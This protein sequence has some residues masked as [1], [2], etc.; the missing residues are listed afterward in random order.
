MAN[1]SSQLKI[2]KS[3]LKTNIKKKKLVTDNLNSKKNLK[4]LVLKELKKGLKSESINEKEETVRPNYVSLTKF[5]CEEKQ[6]RHGVNTLFKLMKKIKSKPELFDEEQPIFLQVTC[7]KIPQSPI[8]LIR[9]NLNHSLLIDTS[10]ICLIVADKGKKKDHESTIEYYENILNKHGITNIKT[11]LPYNQFKAEYGTQ[12]ELK[13]KLLGLYDFFLVD[14]KVCGYV[15]HL[16]GSKFFESR[17]MPSIV[18]MNRPTLKEHFKNATKKTIL[19]M[20]S[21]GDSYNVQVGHTFM[22]EQHICE[23]IKGIIEDFHI[24]FPGGLENIRALGIKTAKSLTIPIYLTL[25]N[26]SEVDIP[27][28]E[29]PLP[30]KFKTVEGELS[31]Q[32]DAWVS[33]T[34]EGDVK[35]KNKKKKDPHLF[36]LEKELQNHDDMQAEILNEDS[37]EINV[38]KIKH[39]LSSDEENDDLAKAEEDYLTNYEFE[40]EEAETKKIKRKD[41][42]KGKKI[43]K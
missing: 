34:P 33:L 41:S 10:E 5:P 23:N 39:E 42:R 36:E 2:V 29:K 18:N 24:Q 38:E 35:I 6:I 9:Y 30:K 15:R 43:K 13:I 4:S 21:K 17:K 14:S 28:C 3:K 16:L 25:K 20:H 11:I 31:T 32:M 12:N 40:Q 22:S 27:V 1:T 7:V 26:K 8:R 19:K 37:N